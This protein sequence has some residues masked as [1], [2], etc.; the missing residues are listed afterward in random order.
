MASKRPRTS[1]T[2]KREVALHPSRKT[3]VVFCEGE[4]TEPQ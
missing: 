3:L 2:L 4:K 1:R